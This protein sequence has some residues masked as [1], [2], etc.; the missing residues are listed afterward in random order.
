MGTHM[1]PYENKTVDLH[2]ARNEGE[3]LDTAYGP[4]RFSA[5]MYCMS[6]DVS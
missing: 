1:P 4:T 5:F 3:N 2:L 6:H